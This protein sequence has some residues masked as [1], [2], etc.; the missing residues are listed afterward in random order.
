MLLMW[1]LECEGDRVG[2]D[3]VSSY[4]SNGRVSLMC[5]G[6]LDL[7][8]LLPTHFNSTPPPFPLP[9]FHPNSLSHFT[10]STPY[11]HHTL[12]LPPSLLNIIHLFVCVRVVE[13]EG[14]GVVRS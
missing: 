3:G 10:L 13:T 12:H 1:T 6:D 4:L 14:G 2:V 11:P 8:A 7:T 5:V 9:K